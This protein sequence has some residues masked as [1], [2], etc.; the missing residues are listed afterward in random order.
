MLPKGRG[1]LYAHINFL[2]CRVK[3]RNGIKYGKCHI[4]FFMGTH[5]ESLYTN[6]N[7]INDSEDDAVDQDTTSQINTTL[8]SAA[9]AQSIL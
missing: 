1:F 2:Y 9:A 5:T 4:E 3:K 7:D 6:R 8:E